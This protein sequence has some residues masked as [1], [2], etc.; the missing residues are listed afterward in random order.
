M[1]DVERVVAAV[2]AQLGKPIGWPAPD[3]YPEGLALCVLDCVWSLDTH[4]DRVV[5]PLLGRYR[6]HRRAAGGDPERDGLRAL[7]DVFD[8]L[9]GSEAFAERI[10]TR[11]R[12]YRR[13]TAPLKAAAVEHAAR[14][15]SAPAVGVDSVADLHARLVADPKR[16]YWAWKSTPGQRSSETGWRYLLLLAGQDEVKP[17]RMVRRFLAAALDV[18]DVPEPRAAACVQHAAREL[19]V[20]ARALDHAIWR[21]QSG[22]TTG[23][24]SL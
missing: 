24:G 17:D 10:G 20:P 1:G 15:L 6:A 23:G 3:G 2:R 4:Y 22:R 5:V 21:H 7:L 14:A 9:G 11:H 19:G 16:V 18:P 8:G 13:A 12:A